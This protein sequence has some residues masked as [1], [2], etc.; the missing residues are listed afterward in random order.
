LMQVLSLHTQLLDLWK[1]SCTATCWITC[2]F[3][4]G[5]EEIFFAHDG[6]SRNTAEVGSMN[7]GLYTMVCKCGEWRSL[8]KACGC[9]SSLRAFL[10]LLGALLWYIWDS[11]ITPGTDWSRWTHFY[12]VSVFPDVIS[13]RLSC[14]CLRLEKECVK[15]KIQRKTLP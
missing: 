4:L 7:M 14:K 3:F 10:F 8:R 11:W 1:S 12:P 13:L 6:Y 9:S 15:G 2:C 5:P